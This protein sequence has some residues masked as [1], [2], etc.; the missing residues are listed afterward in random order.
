MAKRE[1]IGEKQRRNREELEN[2]AIEKKK[3]GKNRKIRK[4]IDKALTKQRKWAEIRENRDT[5]EKK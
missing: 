1:T 2:G 4:K 5:I 3:L